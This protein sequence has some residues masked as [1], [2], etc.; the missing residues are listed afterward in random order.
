MV[1]VDTKSEFCAND[2]A[3]NCKHKDLILG[4]LNL[5]KRDGLEN[6]VI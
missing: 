5:W 2:A 1:K 6:I 4:W 3:N